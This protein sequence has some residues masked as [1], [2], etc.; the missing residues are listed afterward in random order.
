M[1][2]E[3]VL[4]GLRFPVILGCSTKRRAKLGGQLRGQKGE[5]PSWNGLA[6]ARGIFLL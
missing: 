1:G 4:I 2:D 6:A 3:N 5:L